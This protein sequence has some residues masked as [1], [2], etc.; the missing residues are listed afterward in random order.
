M[1]G[2]Q[3]GLIVIIGCSLRGGLQRD[4]AVAE[5][6]SG[7]GLRLLYGAGVE[8]LGSATRKHAARHGSRY[9]ERRGFVT[10]DSSPT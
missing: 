6:I 7:T 2:R 10:Q 8:Q 1:A 9:L 4:Q 5:P 3:V